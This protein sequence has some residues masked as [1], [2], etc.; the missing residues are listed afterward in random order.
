MSLRHT[1]S[2]ATCSLALAAGCLAASVPAAQAAPGPVQMAPAT[3]WSP[4]APATAQADLPSKA[5]IAAAKGD[6]EALKAM[7]ARLEAGIETARAQVRDA[8]AE[9]L[10]DQ[11]SLLASDETL[12]LR[13]QTAKDAR[14]EADR[15]D[16]YLASSKKQMGAL[17]SDLYR[18]GGVNPGVSSLLNQGENNDL[19]YKASTM[20]ALAANRARM[21][22]TAEQASILSQAW[23]DYAAAAEASA[24][25]AADT[26]TATAVSAQAS[27]R[28][29]EDLL[30]PRQEL[31]DQL[32]TDLADLRGTNAKAERKRIEAQ[33]AADEEKRLADLIANA[34]QD[35]P[36]TESPQPEPPVAEAPPQK[37]PSG[38]ASPGNSFVPVAAVKPSK[39]PAPIV[40]TPAPEPEV[41]A[42]PEPSRPEPTPEAPAPTRTPEAPKPSPTTQAPK[43]PRETPTATPSSQA[44]KPKPTPEAPKPPKPTPTPEPTK[45]PVAPPSGNSYAAAIA[46][47]QTIANDDSKRYRYGANGPD[48]YDCS[49]YTGAA[50]AKSG[51]SLPRTSSQQYAAAPTKVPLSQLKRGDLVFSSSNGGASFYHVAIYL[52]NGQV[53][54]AR[55]PNVGISVTPL[56]W[57]NNIHPYAGRY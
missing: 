4:F 25:E 16:K 26:H 14:T 56:S 54:H 6:P 8:E 27:L 23:Q 28:A 15:A 34:P 46:W 20:G 43:P 47:A 35:P 9:A 33:E 49:S 36:V 13:R 52:G 37:A 19:L 50:F 51:I 11:D 57:V 32:I 24:Q 7:V 18:T 48:F 10:V 42:T 29:Y 45:P 55:N 5:E 44:P 38:E 53:I 41:P 39:R 1:L 17:V 40:A 31:R 30:T 3:S 21:V 2:V 22:D 12:T